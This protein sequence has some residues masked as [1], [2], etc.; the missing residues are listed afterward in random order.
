LIEGHICC[1]CGRTISDDDE[2][3]VQLIATNLWERKA[4]Q[5]LCA[6]AEC[7]SERIT[8][9]DFSAE[10]LRGEAGYTLEEIVWGENEAPRFPFWG[11]VAVILVLAAGAYAI[12]R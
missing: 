9:G 3:A 10:D 8:E 12:F 2:A 7:A 6:H 1:F 5:P 4:A 11:C